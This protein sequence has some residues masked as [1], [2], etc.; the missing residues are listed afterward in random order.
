MSRADIGGNLEGYNAIKKDYKKG[1]VEDD[2]NVEIKI[3]A[4]IE[5][6]EVSIL[7]RKSINDHDGSVLKARNMVMR[8]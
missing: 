7:E 2:G 6:K 8:V 3:R 5:G 1:E 4:L